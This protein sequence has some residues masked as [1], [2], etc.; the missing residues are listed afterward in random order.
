[1]GDE[2]TRGAD[3][4]A[5]EPLRVLQVGVD[6]FQLDDAGRPRSAA[7]APSGSLLA[8]GRRLPPGTYGGE[9]GDQTVLAL[10]AGRVHQPRVIA[11]P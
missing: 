7:P 1:M 9:L 6:D 8:G 5:G 3:V 11:S 10:P 2:R 4:P